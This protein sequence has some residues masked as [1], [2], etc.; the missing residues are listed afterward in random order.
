MKIVGEKLTALHA[1]RSAD[2]YAVL[3]SVIRA[4]ADFSSDPMHRGY[5][6]PNREDAAFAL[7]LATGLH[8]FLARRPI[9]QPNP[10]S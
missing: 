1:T 4:V 10:T 9:S 3:A 8:A 6:V 5:D 7:S 2:P